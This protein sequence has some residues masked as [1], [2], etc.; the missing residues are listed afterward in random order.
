M[1]PRHP[2]RRPGVAAALHQQLASLSPGRAAVVTAASSASISTS[3]ANART[4]TTSVVAGENAAPRL[5]GNLLLKQGGRRYGRSPPVWRCLA[6]RI[7]SQLCDGALAARGRRNA[8]LLSTQRSP[9]RGV[10]V[11]SP[12]RPDDQRATIYDS[13]LLAHGPIAP[14]PISANSPGAFGHGLNVVGMED[15]CDD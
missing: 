4:R 5:F 3:R 12:H 10:K 15:R 6:S 7:A 9:I 13:L 2:R 14:A 11:I 8:Q 1:N